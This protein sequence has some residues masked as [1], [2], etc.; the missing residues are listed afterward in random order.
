M[1][2]RPQIWLLSIYCISIVSVTSIARGSEILANFGNQDEFF[3]GVA[4]APAQVEDHLDDIWLEFAKDGGVAAWDNAVEPERHIDFWSNPDAEIELAAATGVRVFR[5]GVDWGRLVPHR[6]GSPECGGPCPA[7]VQNTKALKHYGEI[8]HKIR[9]RGMK[10]MMTLMHHSV[11][12]WSVREYSETWSAGWHNGWQNRTLKTYF[13]AFA[14]DVIDEFGNEVDYWVTMNEPTVYSLL[15]YAA[16][17]WP[18]G[19]GR[20]PTALFQ[21]GNLEGA[22]HTSNRNMA[23]AHCEVADYIRTR[24]PGRPVGVANGYAQH[25]PNN[26]FLDRVTVQLVRK[27]YNLDFPDLTAGCVDFIGVNYYGEE[28][29]SGFGVK[30]TNDREHSESGR[31]ISPNGMLTTLR[32]VH[33]RYNINRHNRLKGDQRVLP[34]FITEN[35]VSDSTDIIRRPYLLEHLLAVNA[36]R[37][38]G[39]PVGGYVFWTISDNWEWADGYCPKFGMVAVDRENNL[40]R[41]LRPSFALYSAIAKS[42]LIFARQRREAWKTLQQS[43][44][45]GDL[46]PFCRDLSDGQSSLDEPVLVPFRDIDWRFVPTKS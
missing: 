13:S 43:V 38:E 41:Q 8:L 39:I 17:I 33:K 22:Y 45:R 29:V 4:T 26:P 15:T 28:V 19:G 6:P 30:I 1:K 32:E 10:V 16:G 23:A 37:N 11:P 40:S 42:G 35:G 44:R 24:F 5:L 12:K 31:A 20:D 2:K 25:R 21:L 14:K 34:I 27:I 3:F 7:G 46:R 36:A 18:P 9:S